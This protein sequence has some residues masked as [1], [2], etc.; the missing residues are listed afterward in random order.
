MHTYSYI[1]LQ[2]EI[3]VYNKKICDSIFIGVDIW[4][5]VDCIA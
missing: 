5:N 3:A 4:Q 1:N 2:K